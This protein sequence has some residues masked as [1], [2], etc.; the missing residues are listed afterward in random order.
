MTTI[1]IAELKKLAMQSEKG[2]AEFLKNKQE[3]IQILKDKLEETCQKLDDK[4]FNSDDYYGLPQSF[5]RACRKG[6]NASQVDVF[7]NFDIKDFSNWAK[8]VPF[9]P[10]QYGR[11]LNARPSNCLKRYL[12]RAHEIGKLPPN[13]AFHVWGNKKF[14]VKFEISFTDDD[15]AED[16][17]E[18]HTENHTEDNTQKT[19]DLDALDIGDKSGE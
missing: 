10:D 16:H 6:G 9:V 8:F 7:I 1:D 18:D 12:T 11:N 14:T 3:R 5:T 17:T 4:I 19:L 2:K 15:N 13:V